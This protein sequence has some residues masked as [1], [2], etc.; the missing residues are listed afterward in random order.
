MPVHRPA[1]CSMKYA[2]A[3]GV[4]AARL[5]SSA[6]KV[7]TPVK[8]C[9]SAA[10]SG[11]HGVIGGERPVDAQLFFPQAEPGHLRADVAAQ[12]YPPADHQ[13]DDRRHDLPVGK[14]GFAAP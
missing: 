13:I 8:N 12:Q 1:G 2:A 6:G 7:S 4:S 5:A 9:A 14:A 11:E 3:P 10:S